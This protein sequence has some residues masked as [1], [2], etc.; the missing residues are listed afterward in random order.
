[1]PSRWPGSP[2]TT[3]L[4][5]SRELHTLEIAAAVVGKAGASALVTDN[6]RAVIEDRD[7]PYRP[8]PV[9]PAGKGKKLILRIPDFL[10]PRK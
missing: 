9:D 10:R 3:A 6:P 4:R 1:M 5:V 8:E 7:I 2:V